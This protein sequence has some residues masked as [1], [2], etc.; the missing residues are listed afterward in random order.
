VLTVPPPLPE[1]EEVEDALE[2]VNDDS[3]RAR[4][5]PRR[6]VEEAVQERRRPLPALQIPGSAPSEKRPPKPPKSKRSS[7]RDRSERSRG[8]I[9][10]HPSI[11][12]GVLMMVGAVVWFFLGLAADRIFIYPPILFVLGIGAVIR[13]FTGQD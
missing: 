12:T 10:V 5:V 11:I 2:V 7:R 8:G 4:P 3:P 9:A 1:V 6:D 13:G